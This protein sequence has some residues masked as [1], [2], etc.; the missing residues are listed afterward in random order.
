MMIGPSNPFYW[1]TQAMMS[2]LLGSTTIQ[3]MPQYNGRGQGGM[4]YTV[5][6]SNQP[7]WVDATNQA[8][9]SGANRNAA[10]YA[11]VQP[12]RVMGD[13]QRYMAD[14]QERMASNANALRSR[15]LETVL[16][17]I[18][19]PLTGLMGGL[20]GGMGGPG[21]GGWAGG[22]PVFGGGGQQQAVQTRPQGRPQNGILQRIL[23]M[24]AQG[25]GGQMQQG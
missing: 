16:P 6:H 13:T 3:A 7:S 17:A 18:M 15:T 10:T 9:E 11:Q 19:G 4:G 1:T 5:S 25:Q 20:G 23:A 8:W 22:G 24:L 2:P 21:G 14:T 12:Y